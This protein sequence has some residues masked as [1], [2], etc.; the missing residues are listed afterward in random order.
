MNKGN[1]QRADRMKVR[2]AEERLN[3][4]LENH[5]N[6]TARRRQLIKEFWLDVGDARIRIAN[7]RKRKRPR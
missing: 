2:Y 3:E 4:I 1:E 7:R 6:N 5:P